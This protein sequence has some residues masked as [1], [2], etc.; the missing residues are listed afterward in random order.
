MIRI[1]IQAWFVQD[2]Q[3]CLVIHSSTRVIIS[4]SG[5]FFSFS[6][7]HTCHLFHRQFP[8]SFTSSLELRPHY[9]PCL[10]I[11]PLP[12][13]ESKL[14][15]PNDLYPQLI[16]ASQTGR[17]SDSKSTPERHELQCTYPHEYLQVLQD[18]GI[19]IQPCAIDRKKPPKEAFLKNIISYKI[20][21]IQGYN[22]RKKSKTTTR[23]NDNT[24]TQTN[25]T[26]NTYTLSTSHIPHPHFL[27]LYLPLH[28]HATRH[29]NSTTTKP[30]P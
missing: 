12:I 17:D 3:K 16:D 19:Q 29:V 6:L 22:S 9:W 18:G 1:D 26:P 20:I 8:S 28:F 30:S 11:P 13:K 23:P 4:C 15:S 25:M 27:Y 21:N 7:N 10:Q 14:R 24:K 2:R 5:P